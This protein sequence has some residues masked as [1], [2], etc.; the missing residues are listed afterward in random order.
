MVFS[1]ELMFLFLFFLVCLTPIEETT[2]D[3]EDSSSGEDEEKKQEKKKKRLPNPEALRRKVLGL[4][5]RE[6]DGDI[7]KSTFKIPDE[8]RDKI[9][10]PLED[11]DFA[12]IDPVVLAVELLCDPLLSSRESTQWVSEAF[13]PWYGELTTGSWW[14]DTE[15][16]SRCRALNMYLMALKMYADG[17]VPGFKQDSE[18]HPI[19]FTCDNLKGALTR[20][21]RGKFC[22]GYWPKL[23]YGK[24][25]N[26]EVKKRL[27]MR[28]YH[29]VVSQLM[30]CIERYRHGISVK[31][32]WEVK[33]LV[34]VLSCVITDW[35]EG[36]KA[37]GV[38]EG[39][40]SA[41]RNCRVCMRETATF[42]VTE[43][44][45]NQERRLDATARRF[46]LQY[47]NSSVSQQERTTQEKDEGCFAEPN[48]FWA[49]ELYSN[50]FGIY[51]LFPMDT[52][53]TVSSGIVSELRKLVQLYVRENK[54]GHDAGATLNARLSSLPGVHDRER[55]GLA[56]RYFSSV[57]HDGSWTGD[58]YIALL[59]QLPF[60]VGTDATIIPDGTARRAFLQAC[61]ATRTILVVLKHLTPS[62]DNVNTLH[63]AA[64]RL[65]PLLDG[66][67]SGLSEVARGELMTNARPKVHALL[68][69][70]YFIRRYGSALNFDTGTFELFHKVVVHQLFARDANRKE[71]RL[72]RFLAYASAR[73]LV[74]RVEQAATDQPREVQPALEFRSDLHLTLEQFLSR[75]QGPIADAIGAAVDVAQGEYGA[76]TNLRSCSLFGVLRATF[77]REN[78]VYA[79]TSSYRGGGERRDTVQVEWE[80]YGLHVAQLVCLF[81]STQKELRG[82]EGVTGMFAVVQSWEPVRQTLTR[83]E[84]AMSYTLVGQPEDNARCYYV[85]PV[86]A[87][88]GHAHVVPHYAFVQQFVGARKRKWEQQSDARL[89]AAWWWD[90]VETGGVSDLV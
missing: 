30:A 27:N 6:Q 90:R 38:K 10:V 67:A 79:C 76:A 9:G 85:L 82:A 55:R 36:Q 45:A 41:F 63:E 7:I 87:I 48:G 5:D 21:N 74:A 56:Y 22:V 40:S 32:P 4:A 78:L 2:T 54:G 46:V 66:A 31:L 17:S 69:F 59:Q 52:L 51:S 18:F 34:P 60:V 26:D 68:H 57:D 20:T 84:K 28:L 70:R 23:K 65:G 25:V 1:A 29:W 43:H 13:R 73:A 62:E 47:F 77:Q 42:G 19:V 12:F 35:P 89:V 50:R 15:R 86:A 88:A 75:L 3:D 61:K 64:K 80:G 14:R 8:F 16:R 24:G 72:S 53:H 81:G 39:A 83:D 37:A 33:T 58:D 49:G 11:V 71:G 44:G